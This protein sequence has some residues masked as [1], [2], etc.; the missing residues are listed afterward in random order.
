MFMSLVRIACGL[1]IVSS[2][3]VVTGCRTGISEAEGMAGADHRSRPLDK[4]EFLELLLYESHNVDDYLSGASY[5]FAK[6]DA[7][8]GYLNRPRR[9]Q[10]GLDGSMVVY[11]YDASDA[12]KM[13]MYPGKRC[14]INSY[15]SSFCMG[16]QVND[17]ETW[18]EALAAHL[19]EPVRNYGIGGYSV[20][21]SWLR[22]QR[23]E[24]RNPADLIILNIGNGDHC[25]N[26]LPWQ[27]MRFRAETDKAFH[28]STPYVK[29][30]PDNGLYV[31][32][33][34]PCPTPDSLYNLCDLDK[35]EDM[36]RDDYLLNLLM[37]NNEVQ[38]KARHMLDRSSKL[39]L[40]KPK[41]FEDAF[42][43][44]LI[45]IYL[46]DEYV[47]R[48]NYASIRVL[49]KIEAWAGKH[50]KDVLYVFSYGPF[51]VEWWMKDGIRYDQPLLD[52][53][54]E[55]ELP[56]VDM[57]EVHSDDILE[58]NIDLE[59]YIGRYFVGH[60]YSPAGQHLQAYSIKDKVVELLGPKPHPYQPQ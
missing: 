54:R 5:S 60:S 31:E 59:T 48:S 1:I 26:L 19:G 45:W 17:G 21:H 53:I 57:L 13:I 28:T 56:Y 2:F 47:R 3:L 39:G 9:Y 51:D 24:A 12:R 52:F 8:L 10:E 4:R 27:R 36:F 50:G 40:D 43:S 16:E 44:A 25:L 58:F 33:G 6:Y 55:H 41:D 14:R 30:D 22:M 32:M 38:Q 42:Q 35:V 15:G 46:D 18:Q 37:N 29:V 7:K 23:E 20:Y 34:N 49:E 11:N